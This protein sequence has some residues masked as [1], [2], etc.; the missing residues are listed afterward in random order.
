MWLLSTIVKR[1]VLGEVYFCPV[2][3][4]GMYVMPD[5]K[6]VPCSRYSHLETGFNIK[7]FDLLKYVKKFNKLCS[8]FCLFEN[9]Y[10]EEYW[11][12]EDNPINFQGG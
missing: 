5:E 7:N 4:G 3:F 2:P 1:M 9:K 12:S 11:S 8:N 10:F 6:I